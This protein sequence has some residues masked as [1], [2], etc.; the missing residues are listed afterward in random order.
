[1]RGILVVMLVVLVV[2]VGGEELYGELGRFSTCVAR[3]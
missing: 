2:V 1:M 3:C